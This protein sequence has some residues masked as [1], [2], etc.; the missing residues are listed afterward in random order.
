MNKM[1]KFISITFLTLL[2]LAGSCFAQNDLSSRVPQLQE[3]ARKAN[4]GA[5][6]CGAGRIK[7]VTSHGEITIGVGLDP[8][9]VFGGKI[10]AADLLALLRARVESNRTGAQNPMSGE[11]DDLMYVILSVLRYS[12]DPDAIPVIGQLLEDKKAQ[13]VFQSFSALQQLANTSKELQYAVEKV[14]FPKTAIAL[15]EKYG[16]KLPHWVKKEDS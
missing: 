3:T 6:G 4:G 12:S 8:I 10:V 1:N 16:V 9:H 2:V 7:L 5:L 15:F 11:V 14:V 13:I